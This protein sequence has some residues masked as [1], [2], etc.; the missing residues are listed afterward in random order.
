MM[1]QIG[2]IEKPFKITLLYSNCGAQ[3]AGLLAVGSLQLTNCFHDK[4]NPDLSIYNKGSS[5]PCLHGGCVSHLQICEFISDCPTKE[6]E[7]VRCDSLPEGSHC[8][9][10]EGSCGWTL[11]ETAA[12]PWSISGFN[13]MI[14]NGSFVGSTL[15]ATAGRIYIVLSLSVFL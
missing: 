8:S 10:E 5:F 14:H 13:E 3:E 2:R 11:N 9:F 4:E 6:V 7:G 15:Q 12:F 1:A